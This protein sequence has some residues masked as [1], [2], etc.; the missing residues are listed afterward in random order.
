[1]F[2]LEWCEFCWAVRRFLRDLGVRFRSVDL[3]SVAMQ[4]D[5]LGGDIRKVLQALTGQ[6]TIPQIFIG[7]AHIG[8]A[9]DILDLHDRGE[10][11]TL[12]G[13]AGVQLAGDPTLTARSYLPKWLAARPAA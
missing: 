8:G 2:A 1:M 4:A 6:R 9:V 11:V 12:L 13:K 10:L 3:D 5:G 7:G